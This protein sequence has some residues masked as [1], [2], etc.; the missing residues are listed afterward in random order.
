MQQNQIPE[1]KIMTIKTLIFVKNQAELEETK[2]RIGSNFDVLY[3]NNNENI[4][5]AV[6]RIVAETN[7]PECHLHRFETTDWIGYHIFIS[8]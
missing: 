8:I 4:E 3:E 2:K 6:T 7:Q 5:K 1:I